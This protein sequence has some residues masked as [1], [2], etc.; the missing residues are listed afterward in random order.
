VLVSIPTIRPHPLA[1]RFDAI[2]EG[3]LET[4]QRN[5]RPGETAF[6]TASRMLLNEALAL[7]GGSQKHAAAELRVTARVVNERARNL[8]ARPVDN[9]TRGPA[10]W[11]NR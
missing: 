1:T 10:R 11:A 9:G 6:E 2:H 8:H 5:R 4:V 7:Y 3:I